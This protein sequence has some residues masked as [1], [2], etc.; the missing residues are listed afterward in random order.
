MLKSSWHIGDVRGRQ[1]RPL[2]MGYNS[3]PVPSCMQA[4]AAA[5]P[6]SHSA[7]AFGSG[8]VLAWGEALHTAG[9]KVGDGMHRRSL[10]G[11][12]IRLFTAAGSAPTRRFQRMS[13]AGMTRALVN[14]ETPRHKLTLHPGL[15]CCRPKSTPNL[16]APLH[17]KRR[18][19]TQWLLL[20]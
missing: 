5:P 2:A 9:S 3:R 7:A 17:P 18:G 4:A 16:R 6:P 15:C 19:K 8:P 11:Q 20:G 1:V 12:G 13:A 10:R 14:S